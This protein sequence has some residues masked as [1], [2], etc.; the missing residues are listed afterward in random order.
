MPHLVVEHSADIANH[1]NM[2]DLCKT[3]YDT[4]LRSGE[5]D[6]PTIKVRAISCAASYIGTEP[7][8]FAH[9]TLHLMAGRDTKTK[10]RLTQ[11]ILN[12]LETSLP[13]VGSLTVDIKDIDP[14]TYAKRVL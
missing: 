12:A 9:V 7:Q 8:S 10:S 4:A 6:A 2:S 1:Q 11:T 3:L 5:F 13:D 14:A